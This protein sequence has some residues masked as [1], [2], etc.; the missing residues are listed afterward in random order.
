MVLVDFGDGLEVREVGVDWAQVE[1]E[2]LGGERV[3][4]PLVFL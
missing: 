1:G 4:L 2:V 3:L